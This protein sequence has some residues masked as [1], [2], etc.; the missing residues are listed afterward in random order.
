MVCYLL[1]TSV[2]LLCLCPALHVNCMY[3]VNRVSCVGPFVA[4]V[5]VNMS[6]VL[7]IVVCVLSMVY[8]PCLPLDDVGS[9]VLS[10]VFVNCL[11]L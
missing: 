5:I 3:L 10:H 6:L 7:F 11:H 2:S 4:C 1:F 9:Y 8:V